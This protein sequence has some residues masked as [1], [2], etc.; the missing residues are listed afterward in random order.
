MKR[1]SKKQSYLI[2]EDKNQLIDQLQDH[3]HHQEGNYKTNSIRP[4]LILQDLL[5]EKK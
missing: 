5:M 4:I 3:N 1:L 2:K